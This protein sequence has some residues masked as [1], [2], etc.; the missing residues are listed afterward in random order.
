[1]RQ[2][3][4]QIHVVFALVFSCAALVQGCSSGTSSEPAVDGDTD[5]PVIDSDTDSPVLDGDTDSPVIDG[6]TDS[7]VGTGA[8]PSFSQHSADFESIHYS[9]SAQCTVCHDDL[10]D[11][12]GEDVSIGDD[13]S[14]SIMAQAARDPYWIAK[15]AAEMNNFPAQEDNLNDTCSRCHAPMANDAAKKDGVEFEILGEDGLLASS[16]AYFDHAMEGVSCTLCH[17]IEDNGLLGTA[18]GTSGQFSVRQYVSPADRPAYGQYPDPST[19]R[20]VRLSNFNPVQA[21]HISSSGLCASCHD[22]SVP[23]VSADGDPVP[24]F[25]GEVFSEQMIFTEWSGS[26]FRD[27]GL[28]EQN[29]Q[30]CHMPPA[31]GSLN[32]AS[33]G[34]G[35]ER[36]DV[37]RH[38]FLAANTV[39]QAILRDYRNELGIAVSADQFD[40]SIERNRAFLKT[41]ATIKVAA[42][43][44]EGGELIL[45]VNVN[46][47]TGHKLP[48]GYPSRRVFINLMVTGSNGEVVFESGRPNAD[49]SIAGQATDDDNRLYEPHYEE[50]TSADQVQVYEAIMS[51]VEGGVTHSLVAAAGY[52]KD[53]RLLPSGLF[54]S[55]AVQSIRV[56][57][58]ASND[59]DFDA[60]GDSITYR[61]ALGAN[62][63]YTVVAALRYQPLAY[64]HLQY[65]FESVEVPEVDQFK[66]MFDAAVL[67]TELIASDTVSVTP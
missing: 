25:E 5:S 12:A 19:Q 2:R 60:G 58:E 29:C 34:G 53:N 7:P 42:A 20:M 27:G 33:L 51:D 65:L 13:W 50:I 22:L 41:A 57:G 55:S 66:T 44:I 21:S 52:I 61:M 40:R 59:V 8:L 9:G 39:M 36:E 6:D 49:G 62:D 54:K 15:V 30:G 3:R 10:Q 56:T 14:A 48:G 43:R 47:K 35:V 31:V 38:S 45:D 1:M 4:L 32:I 63:T 26:D 24:G 17:Q 64:G 16:N 18:D 46:N 37:S 23:I 28:L 67:K 11:D